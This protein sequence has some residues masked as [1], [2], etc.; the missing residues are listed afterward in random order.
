MSR[1]C[2]IWVQSLLGTGHLRRAMLLAQAL[3]EAG[4]ETTLANGGPP[5]PWRTP[6]GVRIAQLPPLR[7][8]DTSFSSLMDDAGHAPD[9]EF[10]DVRRRRL[11]AVHDEARPRVVITEMFPFGRRAF[12]TEV[13]ALLDR[14]ELAV[15]SVRDVL[16]SKPDPARHAWM[17]DLVL[18]RYAGV[19][20]HGDPAL[21]PFE[22][23]FPFTD[24]I[25]DRVRYTGFVHMPVDRA[26]P[27]AP[28]AVVV[29]AGGGS[30]GAALLRSACAARQHTVLASEPWLLVGGSRLPLSEKDRLRATLPT[31]VTLCE[32]RD[33]LAALAGAARVAVSQAGYNTVIEGLL[34]GARMV[35]VPF[36]AGAEDEQTRRAERLAA[37]G[38]ADVVSERELTPELLAAAVDRRCRVAR[39]ALDLQRDGGRRSAELLD[40]LVTEHGGW[41]S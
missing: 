10:W 38:L 3:A 13:A 23:S 26:A 36:A 16:V 19:L 27:A 37:L 39:P 28:P 9:D 1:S 11:L 18:E 22:L 41:R 34:H 31:G 8:R 15:A 4:I 2:L 35:L 7:A 20:V 14:A 25:A 32:H 24:A 12:R 5:S 17:R 33:D 21:F 29:S 6:P 40:A 30:V